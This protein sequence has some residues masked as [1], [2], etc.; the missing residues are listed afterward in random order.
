MI[1]MGASA[2]VRVGKNIFKTGYGTEH[3]PAC[4][5]G[6]LQQVKA[7]QPHRK[8]ATA[9]T[10]GPTER[11]PVWLLVVYALLLCMVT[12]TLQKKNAHWLATVDSLVVNGAFAVDSSPLK[13]P[14]AE[15]K[16]RS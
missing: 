10:A 5:L 11:W 12:G 3:A 14:G 2:W 1:S 16:V 15:V 6:I 13:N 4:Q 7:S 9:P 8:P